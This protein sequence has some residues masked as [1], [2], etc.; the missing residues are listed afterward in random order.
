M[1]LPIPGSPPSKTIEPFTNPPPKTLSNSL[2]PL[3]ILVNS[4]I[5][6]SLNSLDLEFSVSKKCFDK[7]PF[8]SSIIEFHSLQFIHLP[9]YCEVSEPQFWQIYFENLFGILSFLEKTFKQVWDI[10]PLQVRLG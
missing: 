1:L 6:I 4:S 3:F 2:K 9:K 5:S 8:F 10:D 7:S